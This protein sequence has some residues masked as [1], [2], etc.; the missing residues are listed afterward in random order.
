MTLIVGPGQ[1]KFYVHLAHLQCTSPFFK[2]AFE[3]QWKEGQD[4][5]IVLPE[6]GAELVELY[7]S[8]VYTGKLVS[9]RANESETGFGGLHDAEYETLSSMYCFGEKYQDAK[10]RNTIIDAMWVKFSED[11]R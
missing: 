4:S 3:K 10:L 6:D 5:S 1:Q 9:R 8:F 11:G 2:A 7:L